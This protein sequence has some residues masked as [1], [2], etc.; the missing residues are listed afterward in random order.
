MRLFVAVDV[1]ARV[2]RAADALVD[3]LRARTA[4]L[5]PRARVTWIPAER[6]HLTLRFIGETD[7]TTFRAIE[8]A[9]AVRMAIPPFDV[10]VAG[11]GAFPSSGRPRVLWA[12]ISS[13]ADTLSLL[14]REVTSRLEK[15]GLAPETKP[16]RPH[17]TLA[18]IRDASTL[19][20][21]ELMTGLTDVVLGTIHV[22]ASTL[23][24]SR[25]SPQG[26]AHIGRQTTRLT[27]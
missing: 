12:G 15:V 20:S 10:T 5:A 27:G 7:E 8:A 18:R 6:M 9:L 14:E 2:A 25:L 11:A 19:R 16:Y 22:D 4:R 21:P 26:P 13:G 17:L 24:E 3:E 1:G 23:F